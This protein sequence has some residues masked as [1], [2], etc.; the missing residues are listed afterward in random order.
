MREFDPDSWSLIVGGSG[1]LGL[2]TARKLAR[3]GMNLCIVHRDRR[4]AL[5]GVESAMHGLGQ[6]GVQVLSFNLDALDS[7]NRERVL[8][9][10]AQR[11]GKRGRVLMLL[12]AIA[13]GSLKLLAPHAE[14]P[15]LSA[16]REAL[17][18]AIDVPAELLQ[19]AIE[20]LFAEG[21]DPLHSLARPPA[22]DCRHLLDR[23][24]FLHTIHAMGLNLVEWVRDLHHRGLFADDAR[25][26]SLTSEGNSVAW[27]GYAAVSAAKAVLESTTRAIALEYAP[28]GLRANVVQAGI[29]DTKALRAVPGYRHMMAQARLRNPMRRL[30]T[31]EA[32]ADVIYLL[33]TKEAAWV[34]GALIRV[35]G[36]EGIA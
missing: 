33:C 25:V 35:D 22:Y 9:E 6:T 30:T 8:S 18:K 4:A 1:G 26:L 13:W 16:S 12:H 19:E 14:D 5:Q 15:A 3:H 29:T 28:F 27:R 21:I 36:G 20:T 10:L 17:A 23:E 7:E 34:N 32:V 2:A 31:P 24:D 11:L